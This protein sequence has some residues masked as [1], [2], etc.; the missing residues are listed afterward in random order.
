M[1]W[2]ILHGD[3]REML[4]TLPDG[5]VQCCVTSPPYFG[6][7]RDY[8]HDKQIGLE[9]EPRHYVAELVGVFQSVRRVLAD[10]GVLWLN[11]G[12]A[13]A[14]SGKGGGG[15]RGA[16]TKSWASVRDRKGL[17]MP[18]AGYKLKDLTLTPFLVADALRADGWY[19]RSVI[20]WSKPVAIE[21]PRVDRPSSSHEYV[22]LLSKSQ[23]YAVTPSPEPW[24]FKT[25][26]DISPE[27]SVDHQATM[28]RELV[29]RC[30]SVTANGLVLDPFC[31]SGT[32]GV[33]AD[34]MGRDFI[35]IELNPEYVELGRRRI[36]S[37]TPLF[38][39]EISA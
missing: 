6:G 21:P 23:H 7:L 31:G 9:R 35:G 25:V 14:A 3:V 28:P 26:W 11:L 30:L 13:Y 32:T 19:L 29:R 39:N 36:G 17:R 10:D 34:A 1:S 18:P 27:N 5:S 4:E 24:W 20:I 37:V 33:V 22:F 38:P 16:R 12:D 8:G 2:R 15:I